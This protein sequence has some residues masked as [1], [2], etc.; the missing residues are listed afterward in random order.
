MLGD[1]WGVTDAEVGRAYPCDD[2]VPSPAWRAWRGVTVHA[3]PERVWPW[4][5]QLQAAPYSYDLVDNLGR[6]SPRHLLD[7]PDPTAG[8]PFLRAGG[9]PFGRV[10]SVEPGEHVTGTVLGVAMT[11]LLV[12][13]GDRTRLLL[14]LVS[15]R[16]RV[17]APLVVLGDLV[18]ARRQLLN[19]RDLAEGGAPTH[20]SR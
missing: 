17:V 9:R 11:Y 1:R 2:L 15:D 13:E 3:P 5:R 10:A 12:P 6:R 8:D 14:K 16:A 19:F 20:P 4:V 18:M 7:L